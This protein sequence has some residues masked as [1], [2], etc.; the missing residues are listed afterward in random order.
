MKDDLVLARGILWG[1]AIGVWFWIA[2]IVVV[3]W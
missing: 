1:V 3:I 2:L